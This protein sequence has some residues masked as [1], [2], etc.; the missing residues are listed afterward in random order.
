LLVGIDAGSTGYSSVLLYNKMGYHE[1]FRGWQGARVRDGYFQGVEDGNPVLWI[2]VGG[3]LVYIKFPRHGLN[4]LQESG[5]E[6]QPEAVIESAEIQYDDEGTPTYY[7]E[8]I[9]HSENLN[10]SAWV[11]VDFQYNEDVGTGAWLS[12]D[13]V[14]E[15]PRAVARINVGEA[16][17]FKY[18][19]RLVTQDAD[20]IPIVNA[21]ELRGFA[22]R[23]V[24]YQWSLRAKVSDLQRTYRGGRDHDPNDFI[25]FLKN[26]AKKAK[27]VFVRSKWPQFD[28][29]YVIVEPPTVLRTYT[30]TI[31]KQ[32]EG[33]IIPFTVREG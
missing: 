17:N 7:E 25:S 14:Y 8:L 13:A 32:R 1:I 3:E 2:N 19:L 10:S 11:E 15:S 9:I 33:S 28:D 27:R 30:T 26:A 12:A 5:F 21:T 4:P 6:V 20:Q 23:P 29:M 16:Y 31:P 24:H 22:R 18:R